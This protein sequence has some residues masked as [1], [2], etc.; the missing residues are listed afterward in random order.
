MPWLILFMVLLIQLLTQRLSPTI[1]PLSTCLSLATSTMARPAVRVRAAT[2]GLLRGALT[3]VCTA[4]SR[5]LAVS[6][7]STTPLATTGIVLDVLSAP[8]LAGYKLNL[9]RF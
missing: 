1:V 9:A 2:G 6:T 3:V 7:Q 5:I 4:C 8:S